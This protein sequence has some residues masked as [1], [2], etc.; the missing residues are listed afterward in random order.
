MKKLFLKPNQIINNNSNI[1]SNHE[2]IKPN[3]N[4]NILEKL[5]LNNSFLQN[6]NNITVEYPKNYQPS[7]TKSPLELPKIPNQKKHMNINN[8]KLSGIKR[9]MISNSSSNIYSQKVF[10][11]QNNNQKL[12]RKDK[13]QIN[14][15]KEEDNDNNLINE[16]INLINNTNMNNNINMI[17][18]NFNKD[19]MSLFKKKFKNQ[20]NNINNITNINIHIYS[21]ENQT[22]DDSYQRNTANSNN[23]K[24][25]IIARDKINKPLNNLPSNNKNIFNRNN[26]TIETISN[27]NNRNNIFNNRFNCSLFPRNNNFNI[28]IQKRKKIG[29]NQKNRGGHSSS[30]EGNKNS[31]LAIAG[32]IIM[33]NN[34]LNLISGNNRSISKENGNIYRNKPN[35]SLPEI[36]LTQIDVINKNSHDNQNCSISSRNKTLNEILEEYEEINYNDFEKI[37]YSSKFL[38]D[39]NKYNNNFVIFLKIFQIH[40]DIEILL[41]CL[42]INV[43]NNQNNKNKNEINCPLRQKIQ[44]YINNDKQYKL[45]SSLNTYFNLLNEIYSTKNISQNNEQNDLCFFT[46]SILNK[47]FKNCIKSQICL[48]SSILIS[49]SHL[50]IFD[51]NIVLKNFFYKIFKEISFSLYNIFE[52]FIKDELNTEYNDLVKDNLRNDFIDNYN[53]LIKEYKTKDNKNREILKIIINNI[54]KSV[55]SLKF[56]TSSNLKYSLIKP[57]GDSLNQLLFSF[58]QKT[59]YQFVV[60]FL[61]TILYG[62]LELNKKKI[63][64]KNEKINNPNNNNNNAN[65]NNN[66]TNNN[67]NI[68]NDNGSSKINNVKEIPP[69]LPAINPK[70]KFTLVLDVDET[71]I[72]F[73]FTY[74]NGMFFVRPYFFQFINEI[75]KYYEIVTFTAGTKEYADNILNLLDINNNIIKYRL[76]RQHTTIMGCNVFKDLTKLGRDLNR[77]II[78]DN[79]KDNFKLQPNNGLFIK[80]WTSDVNDNQFYDLGRILKDIVLLDVKDVRPVIEK[81]NDDIKISRN[82]INPYS[83]VDIKK[84]LSNL[85]IIN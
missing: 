52:S 10:E 65:I 63:F 8:S 73:F 42:N 61:N 2:T 57:Y 60:I 78:I 41:N 22:N 84:I 64:Q 11:L 39:L 35:N 25:N 50:T 29:L 19:E 44:L 9:I 77:I 5:D 3:T 68:N 74:I 80:T 59:L 7:Y 83:N 62:E 13:T 67:N 6:K 18:K 32:N 81:I 17:N 49:I 70:Y 56:Y 4:Q 47:I 46:F 15:I 16:N 45:L 12:L 14:L 43:N 76:Y 40:L 38:I 30:V 26:S 72:H 51:F 66:N 55:N 79:L 36:N 27:I 33:N 48:F 31:T 71:M 58:D 54:E 82:I 20:N 37:N 69:Y 1:Y 75:N 23:N 85:N 24:K 21:N 53:N 28:R 34:K